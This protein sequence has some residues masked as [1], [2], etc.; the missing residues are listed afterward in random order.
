M[1][2]QHF[3]IKFSGPDFS[4]TTFPDSTFPD[5][6][7]PDSTFLDSTF[8]D[9]AFPDFYAIFQFFKISTVYSTKF[10]QRSNI[11]L[12]NGQKAEY[13]DDLDTNDG[14]NEI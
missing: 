4:G 12:T 14:Y 6:T 10:K 8:L 1:A 11:Q 7:F 2:H 5:P 13:G 3:R 9:P